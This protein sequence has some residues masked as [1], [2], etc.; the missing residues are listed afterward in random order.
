MK[1][2]NGKLILLLVLLVIVAGAIL[3]LPTSVEDGPQAAQQSEEKVDDEVDDKVAQSNIINVDDDAPAFTLEMTSGETITPE[4]LRGKV[5]LVN[6]WATWCPPCREELKRVQSDIVERYADRDFIFLPIS[7][8]EERQKVVDFLAENGY[9]FPV[10]LD[11]D[12]SIFK[13]F[14]K[15]YIPRNYLINRFGVVVEATVGY[16]PEEFDALLQKI[17][18]TLNSR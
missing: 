2:G 14:A 15:E 18:M 6:F 10:G 16:E 12:Q 5:V 17:D 7:R 8:G 11:A 13:L 1:K 4:M 3:L 9:T